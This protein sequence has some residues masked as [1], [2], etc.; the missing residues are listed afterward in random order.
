[1]AGKAARRPGLSL[2]QTATSQPPPP[3]PTTPSL[4]LAATEWNF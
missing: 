1:M 2:R 4:L 3:P